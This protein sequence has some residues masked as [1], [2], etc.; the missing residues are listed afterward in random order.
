MK[1]LLRDGLTQPRS[2]IE[3]HSSQIRPS[4]ATMRP[5]GIAEALMLSRYWKCATPSTSL[6]PT[7]SLF[8]RGHKAP[9]A[10]MLL[11]TISCPPS[12]VQMSVRRASDRVL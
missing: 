1:S 3:P 12:L 9:C 11:S 4:L 2:V 10:F 5:L 7:H 6:T 8:A